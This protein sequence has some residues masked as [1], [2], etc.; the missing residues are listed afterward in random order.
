M[1][2]VRGGSIVLDEIDKSFSFGG[3]YML[4]GKIGC[5]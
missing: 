3:F 4:V 5:I 1:Y 2:K